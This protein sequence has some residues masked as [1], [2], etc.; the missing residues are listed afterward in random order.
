MVTIKGSRFILRPMRKNDAKLQQAAINDKEIA[1]NT[2][3]IPYPYTQ[4]HAKD[5]VARCIANYHKKPLT[6]L[7]FVLDIKKNFA[8]CVALHHIEGHQAELGYWLARKYW[9]QGIMS[10]AAKLVTEYAFT[11]LKLKRIYGCVFP[12]NKK[13][14]HLL[15][16][17][18][19][20][21]E[22]TARKSMKKHGKL[23]DE[24]IFALVK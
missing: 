16:K 18:G 23:L 15:K 14:E 9:G 1:K 20:V 2:A 7:V 19:F 21:Y 6:D 10:E 17:I 5:W 4:K 8:G 11:K 24:K 3:T 22:G 13:S 12:F